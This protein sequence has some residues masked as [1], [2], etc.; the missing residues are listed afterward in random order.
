ML[1]WELA[2]RVLALKELSELALKALWVLAS[3][4]LCDFL[5]LWTSLQS[6][7]YSVWEWG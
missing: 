3:R 7:N 6:Y 4:V 5:A 1:L 2:L